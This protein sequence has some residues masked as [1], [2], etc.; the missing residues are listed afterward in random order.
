MAGDVKISGLPATGAVDGSEVVAVVQAA[1]TKQVLLTTIRTWLGSTFATIAN[2][3]AL[4]LTVAANT[5]RISTL[6]QYSVSVVT[7][8][9]DPTGAASSV[10]AFQAAI[11]STPDGGVAVIRVPQGTYAGDFTGLNY[12]T[13]QVMWADESGTAYPGGFPSMTRSATFSGPSMIFPSTLVPSKH[14]RQ[15]STQ[16]SSAGA[17]VR[18]GVPTVAAGAVTGIS[19]V[20]GGG[21]YGPY[22]RVLISGDG[23][24]ATAHPTIVGGVITAIVVDTGGAGYSSGNVNVYVVD[25][26]VVVVVGD[27]I[28][29]ED[30][31]PDNT[32][33][34][35]WT[36]IKRAIQRDNPSVAVNIF[37]R[38]VGAQ[39]FTNYSTTAN[40]NF[41]IWYNN[42]GKAWLEY[43]REL[44]PDLVIVAFGMNDRENFVFSQFKSGMLTMLAWTRKPDIVFITNA[45]PS[46]LAADPNISGDLAQTGRD[47]TAGYVRSWA[48]YF[49]LGLVDLHRQSRLVRDGLDYRQSCL[50]AV[51]STR[52]FASPWTSIVRCQD[53]YVS[54]TFSA[55][56]AGWWTGRIIKFDIGMT[57]VNSQTQIFVDDDAG[58][59]RFRLRDI[60]PFPSVLY[61][62]QI[63]LT[64]PYPTP[65]SGDV[66][67]EVTIYDTWGEVKVNGNVLYSGTM[68]R[69]S[70]TFYPKIDA[71]V[72]N[73]TITFNAGEF[74]QQTP[75]LTDYQIWGYGTGNAYKGNAQ[76]HPSSV[77]VK[78]L[79]APVIFGTNWAHSPVT[80][81]GQTKA[82]A[83]FIGIGERNPLG[84][85]HITKVGRS[86]PIDPIGNANNLILQDE[87]SPGLSF[88][89][90]RTGVGRINMGDEDAPDQFIQAY[91]HNDN[92]WTMTHSGT[93]IR[94]TYVNKEQVFIPAGIPSYAKAS[95]PSANGTPSWI[96]VSDATGG[97]IPAFNDGSNWRRSDDRTIIV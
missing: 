66:V 46:K 28:S 7:F 1:A 35:Q 10:A 48:E 88:L 63:V 47:A 31:P 45:I 77:G 52:V 55:I 43:I 80:I 68:P 94:R 13:R 27:S 91:N 50:K 78:H 17:G 18:L 36:L 69:Y 19:V 61:S 42:T 82:T 24:N 8:G 96:F 37:N 22:C 26:P 95:L 86:T 73:P 34:S 25:G 12:G 16:Q 54:A 93:L 51:Y 72:E 57:G 20:A 81:S 9:A 4:A 3:T 49:G 85:L 83:N 15:F 5:L 62:D 53:F 14:L 21:D 44:Q 90:S 64:T 40:S 60:V 89:S 32:T 29:T 30:P 76:N 33:E 56:A 11:D 92:T 84:L 79:W 74:V 2:L 39:T 38:A 70:G 67:V 97:A 75:R 59:L 23:F 6:E 41:P 71:G 58:S 87:V 65:T